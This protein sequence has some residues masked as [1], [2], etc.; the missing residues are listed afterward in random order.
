VSRLPADGTLY[1]PDYPSPHPAFTVGDERAGLP[2]LALLSPPRETLAGLDPRRILFGHG[3]GIF[4]DAP[5]ALADALEGAPRRFPRAL[6][7]N[8]PR[9]LR[10]MLGALRG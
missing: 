1:V 6:V 4:E 5:G 2:A 8:L 10:A 9:E 7:A 3:W